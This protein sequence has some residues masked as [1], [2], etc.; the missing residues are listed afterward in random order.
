MCQDYVVPLVV[1]ACRQTVD[2]RSRLKTILS[3]KAYL[4]L[5]K[6]RE[7]VLRPLHPDTQI[8]VV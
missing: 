5:E 6:K 3:S 4:D 2:S 7:D 8:A 1:T